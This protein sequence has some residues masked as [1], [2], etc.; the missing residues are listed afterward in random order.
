MKIIEKISDIK[1]TIEKLKK[2]K[3]KIVMCHGVFDVLHLGHIKHFEEAKLLGDIL[4][5]SVTSNK[6]VNK[7]FDRPFFDLKVRMKALCALE[8]IDFVIPSNNPT[9]VQNLDILR[10]NIYSKGPDYISKPDITQNLTQEKKIL[11]KFNGKIYFT[12]DQQFSSS[13]IINSFKSTFDV[14]QKKFLNDLKKK[15][16][17]EMINSFIKKISKIEAN[18]FGEIIQDVYQF[19]EPIGISGKDPFLV[20]KNNYEKNF[21]GGSFAIAFNSLN[22][23]KKTNLISIFSKE[24]KYQSFF[25]LKLNKKLNLKTIFDDG[26]KNIIKKRYIDK[27]TNSKIFGVYEINEKEIS[28]SS[29]NKIINLLKEYKKKSNKFIISDYGHGLITEKIAKF[30]SKNKFI[31]NLNAQINSANR[32][33]HGLFKFKNPDTIIINASELRY[34]FKD[35]FTKIETLMKLLKRKL[36]AKTVVVT[37]GSKGAVVLNDKKYIYCPAFVKNTRDKVGA[38]DA[39]LTI[40]SLCKFVEMKDDLSIFISSISAANQTK[41]L[42]NEKFLNKEELLKIISHILK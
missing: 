5:V 19:C 13:S 33:Y 23:T 37:R 12:K 34:E 7:G 4:I 27:N 17:F 40:F 32:G 28:K 36:N 38:G 2:D 1:K 21:K 39:L 16:S 26:Y 6:Y 20:F 8:T 41:I 9:A 31:Y 3:K 30:I 25:K 14:D 42:N 10:P 29:E 18:V 24:K 35:R 15:Y 22:F 11:K